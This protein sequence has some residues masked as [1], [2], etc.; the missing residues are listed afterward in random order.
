MSELKCVY[1]NCKQHRVCEHYGWCEGHRAS[2]ATWQCEHLLKPTISE[3]P[4]SEPP[5]NEPPISEPLAKAAFAGEPTNSEPPNS[6]P[7]TS[8]P[9]EVSTSL[10]DN[11]T[12]PYYLDKIEEYNEPQELIEQLAKSQTDYNIKIEAEME[13]MRKK[14][15]KYEENKKIVDEIHQLEEKVKSLQ[16]PP[17]QQKK[18]VVVMPSITPRPVGQKP[19]LTKSHTSLT[20]QKK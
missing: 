16:T 2:L 1:R 13:E 6:E 12:L 7:P 17:T 4:T 15:A 20:T 9:P 14:L 10:L 8:E 5:T 19:A 3:P 11:N 18:R